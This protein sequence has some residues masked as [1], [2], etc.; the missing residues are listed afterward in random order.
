AAAEREHPAS[1]QALAMAYRSG[2]LGLSR[3]E[4]NYRQ[5]LAEAAHALKHPAI[6]P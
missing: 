5:H 6:N 4:S 3:D 1:I 2:E